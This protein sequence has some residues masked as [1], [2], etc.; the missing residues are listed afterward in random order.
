[1]DASVDAFGATTTP[2]TEIVSMS[3]ETPAFQ[4]LVGADLH[5][6]SVTLDNKDPRGQVI[7]RLT[8]STKNV[9]KLN[10]VWLVVEACPFAVTA[11]R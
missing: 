7:G 2:Y 3:H 8:T 10:P 9:E 4:S 1:L 5:K 6:H 11:P